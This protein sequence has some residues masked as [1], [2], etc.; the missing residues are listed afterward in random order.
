R[1]RLRLGCTQGRARRRTQAHRPRVRRREGQVAQGHERVEGAA[2][3]R[4]TGGRH[5]APARRARHRPGDGRPTLLAPAP[6]AA[7]LRVQ[8]PRYPD[9]ASD[10]GRPAEAFAFIV[11]EKEPPYIVT[12]IELP[13]ELVDIG[14][15]RN[16]RALERFR[17]CTES[18]LWPGYIPDDTFATPSA[19]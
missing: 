11:Q 3:R 15:A 6:D 10:I 7:A 13:A 18:G 8:A 2:G 5:P 4:A 12:V 16:Q 14:R 1:V 19:P 17:D 9:L